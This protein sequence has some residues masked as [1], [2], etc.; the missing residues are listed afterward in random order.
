MALVGRT[1]EDR[2]AVVYLVPRFLEQDRGEIRIDGQNIRF[3]T[4]ESLRVQTA[5]VMEQELVFTGMVRD[6]IGCGD[7]S[8]TLQHIVEAAKAAHAHQFIQ[9]LRGGYET[10]IGDEGVELSAGEKFRI[11]LARAIL[12]DP[13]LVVIEEP[14]DGLDEATKALLDDTYARFLSARTVIFLPRRLSTLRSCDQIFL[15]EQG[16]LL[17]SGTHR[18]L[19]E[20]HDLY[21]HL[22]YT[23]YSV[24]SALG[25]ET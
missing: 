24:P 15:F 4:L 21:R 6:N 2:H 13:A 7:P 11:A 5:L 18:A 8:Y 17:D 16:R 19:L 12:R 25:R 9:H 3:A 10:M 20:S 22:I 1:L 23:H 14:T